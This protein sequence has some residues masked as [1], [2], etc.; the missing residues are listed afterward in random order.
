MYK[1]INGVELPEVGI[2]T[3]DLTEKLSATDAENL[4]AEFLARRTE[5]L[6]LIDTAPV[7][8]TEELIGNAVK[9]AMK[10]GVQRQNILL[11]TKVPNDAQGYENTIKSFNE[12]LEKLGV[13]FIDVL[14]IHWPIPRFHEDDYKE[15]NLSTWRAMEKLYK[16]GK[17]RVIGVSNFLPHHLENIINNSEVPPMINQLEIHFWYQQSGTVEYCRQKNIL[18]EA[19]GP[20]RK[21]K[22]FLSDE[23]KDLSAKYNVT[24]AKFALSWIKRRGILPICKSSSLERMLGNLQIPAINFDADDLKIIVDLDDKNGHADF[25]NYKRQLNSCGGSDMDNLFDISGKTVLITGASS[26]IGESAAEMFAARKGG[27]RRINPL[28]QT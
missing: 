11:Q 14:L 27:G 10:N 13:D 2:G 17:V 7:Y 1:L 22:L 19:W 5:N 6:S 25:W 26:G 28:R 16:A 15:L 18:V 20:F 3:S 9:S 12:S 8:G 24:P 23:I 4:L 21:G